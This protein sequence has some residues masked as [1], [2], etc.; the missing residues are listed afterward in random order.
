M[1]ED[2]SAA[3]RSLLQRLNAVAPHL[4]VAPSPSPGVLLSALA[5]AV[6][7]SLTPP[8]V[9]LLAT[10]IAGGYPTAAEVAAVRRALEI[11]DPAERM[12]ASL[13]AV[14]ATAAA[15]RS[16]HVTIE[17]VR[18]AIVDVDFC[19]RHT[20]NTGIQRVVRNTVKHWSDESA[21]LASWSADQTGYRPLTPEQ[22]ALVTNWGS[23]AEA[24]S[25]NESDVLLVPVDST[26]ILPEVPAPT[27]I[28]RIAS[29]AEFSGNRT[30]LIGYDAIP[31]VSADFVS[32]IESDRFAHYLSIVKHSTVVS[33]ISETTAAEFDG[34]NASLRAQGI[35]GPRIVPLPLPTVA[36]HGARDSPEPRAR[37]LVLMVGSIEPR[38]NQLGV[39]AAAEIVW[40]EGVDFELLFIG[41]GGAPQL[42]DL[43]R[44]I[45]RAR[46]AGRVVSHGR[47]VSDSE[48]AAA[49]RDARC[50][51]FPSL[52]EGYGLPVAEALASGI[53]V[54]TTA[55]G[56]TAE[57]ARSGGCVL[58]D[59]RD[60]DDIARA[61]RML[62]TDDAE[63]ARLA[64]ETT[65]LSSLGWS[66]YARSLWRQ[67]MEDAV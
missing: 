48:L 40:G 67:L 63:H 7:E 55:Y 39:L 65:Q 35:S 17:I 25:G 5:D 61:L 29:A 45:Q 30:A 26:I 58:V 6:A 23:S 64:A 43:D 28:E 60:D 54:I 4:G 59:P 47:G 46:G 66:D 51:V 53:P 38:K 1:R 2:A 16:P 41:G 13:S 27:L 52:Q 36:P 20:H 22:L 62:L 32:E 57:I 56:S 49:Y 19:A 50:V 37:P 18:K 9:W 33:A 8:R 24:P 3:L 34:F 15:V 11:A 42:A 31:L 44:G 14:A 21:V 12:G 10:A